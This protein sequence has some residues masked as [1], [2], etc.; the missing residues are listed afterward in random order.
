MSP[1]DAQPQSA[2]SNFTTPR[3]DSRENW[4]AE[5]FALRCHSD[6]PSRAKSDLHRTIWRA[7]MLFPEISDEKISVTVLRWYYERKAKPFLVSK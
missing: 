2:S 1:V 5:H 4:R 6:S 3:T 7:E